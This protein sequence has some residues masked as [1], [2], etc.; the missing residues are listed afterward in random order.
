MITHGWPGSVVEFLEVIGPLTRPGRPRR[1]R[2]RRVPRRVP[3]AA[4]LR[5]S[6]TARR[7]RAGASSASPTA[8]AEL[9]ARARLR[10]LRRPGRRLGFGV[11][12]GLGRHDADHVAG[13]HLNMVVVV[14][15][16]DDRRARPSRSRPRWRRWRTTSSWELGLL[17]AAVD[18]TADAR[19]RPRRLARRPGRV[20][21]RE[22]LGV[23]RL[24]RPSRERRSPRD[25]LLDNVMLYWL[26]GS[27]RVVGPPLLG[28]LQRFARRSTRSTVPVGH[29]DLPEGDHPRRHAG[30]PSAG[31]PTSAIG[32]SSTGAAT[33]PPSSSRRRSST[34]C[35]ARVPRSAERSGA[36][37]VAVEAVDGGE[38]STGRGAAC[39]GWC[40]G[41]PRK[42]VAAERVVLGRGRATAPQPVRRGDRNVVITPPS[43]RPRRAS[44]ML[45]Q[46]G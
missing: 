23:D 13:I 25:E 26:P 15:D 12:T 24:R 35:R 18:P 33:S 19:V 21:R 7:A 10:P 30:G 45:Q 46:N 28:E 8:W 4:R 14:P 39:V 20:D 34:R 9:M 42:I 29:V 11:T 1:R 38:R 27:R 3:V 40:S 5:R 16:A 37:R 22:V 36:E 6:A 41:T 32:T 2:R 43:P 31:S 44:R 17:D